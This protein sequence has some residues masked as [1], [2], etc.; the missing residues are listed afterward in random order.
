[1]A[2][3]L[4]GALG[5]LG[6][7][8]TL[9]A[10]REAVRSLDATFVGLG[11]AVV[12]A[13]LA[14]ALLW[15]RRERPPA[16]RYFPGLVIAALGVVVGFPLLSAQA[17]RH[18][19]A[20]HAAVVTGLLPAATAVM[21]TLRGGERPS[22]AFWLAAA[23]G[24]GAVLLFAVAEGGGRPQ[25]ADLAL[26]AAVVL[27]GL[28]YA[29]GGRLARE[30]GGPRVIC[31][32]LLLAAPFVAPP[33]AIAGL[34]HGFHADGKAWLG[35]GYVSVVSM[36]LAFFAW[37]RGLALGGIAR[38][39]QIQLVQPVLTFAWAALLLGERIDA[40]TVAAGAVVVGVAALG[41][42]ASVR[43]PRLDV[44]GAPVSVPIAVAGE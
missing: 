37:Y 1:M 16:R 14:A 41:R 25:A 43:A 13:A 39:G 36:F 10:T 6:F 5:V 28:G 18:L 8:L 7:S 24:V 34:H 42:R 33:A 22:A 26:L 31:W 11:R 32:A 27:G 2:G 29:E 23:A 15:A 20:S 3:L 38:V 44:G 9:P 12:A 19:P 21:A 40:K 35:F 30:L 4:Y 17:L